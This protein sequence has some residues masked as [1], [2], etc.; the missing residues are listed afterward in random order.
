[1]SG[2]KFKVA[3]TIERARFEKKILRK[4]ISQN[5]LILFIDEKMCANGFKREMKFN[6]INATAYFASFCSMGFTW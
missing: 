5:Q 4:L 6:S 3:A 1:M 2:F